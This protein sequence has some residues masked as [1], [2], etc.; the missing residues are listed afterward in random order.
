[1]NVRGRWSWFSICFQVQ[2]GIRSSEPLDSA[3]GELADLN[4]LH[5]SVLQ[6]TCSKKSN[7]NCNGYILSTNCSLLVS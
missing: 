4:H 7:C 3:A 1:M 6:V 5:C 2:T